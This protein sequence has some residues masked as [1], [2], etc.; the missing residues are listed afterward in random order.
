M[1]NKDLI[2]DREDD[3]LSK[4]MEENR[5]LSDENARLREQLRVADLLVTQAQRY[6]NT[7]GFDHDAESS[8]MRLL[9]QFKE[10][11]WYE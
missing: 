6:V 2:F 8:L 4:A 5:R 1:K 3:D 7:S 10:G 11:K 9:K